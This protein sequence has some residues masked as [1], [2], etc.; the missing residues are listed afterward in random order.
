MPRYYD[1]DDERLPEGMTRVGYDA[2]T[3][4]Y[5]YQDAE[6]NAWEGPEGA[7][8]GTLHR[9]GQD[10][11]ETRPFISS[12]GFTQHDIQE[13]SKKA[14]QYMAP[15]FLLIC[16][17]LFGVFWLLGYS[18]SDAPAVVVC[19]EHT[20]KHTI[21]TGDTCWAIAEGYGVPLE[22]LQHENVGLNCDKL[23]IGQGIC[24]PLIS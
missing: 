19:G 24:V 16:T 22:D 5:T 21:K 2:D 15:F 23:Q 14:W 20:I 6:G 12:S 3:Q 13:D 1:S 11:E 8:Y 7:R 9:V 10:G 17:V 18:S 4:T